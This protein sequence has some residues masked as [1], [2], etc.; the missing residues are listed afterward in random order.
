MLNLEVK[1]K[2]TEKEAV[3]RAKEFFGTGGLGL[4]LSEESAECLSFTGGEGYVN[5]KTCIVDGKTRVTLTTQEWERQ[6]RTFASI[7]R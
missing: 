5:I 7:L 2:L 3:E 6:I 4:V 1:T